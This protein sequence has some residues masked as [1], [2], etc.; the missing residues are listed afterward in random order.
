MIS[1]ILSQSKEHLLY[2]ARMV[3]V[4]HHSHNTE[5]KATPG[6]YGDYKWPILSLQNSGVIYSVSF[7]LV[8]FTCALKKC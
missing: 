4:E 6:S 3:I 1:K 5:P 2:G 8:I 7:D